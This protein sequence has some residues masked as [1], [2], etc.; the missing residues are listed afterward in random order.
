MAGFFEVLGG[1]LVWR[2]VAAPDMTA[3]QADAQMN[4]PVAGLQTVFAT[5]GARRHFMDH[6]KMRARHRITFSKYEMNVSWIHARAKSAS[7]Q[8]F[9]VLVD[10]ADGNRPFANG[11]GHALNG[12]RAHVADGKYARYA[13]L[14]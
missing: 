2:R 4:P 6:I 3:G 9:Q 12:V 14:Q 10:K 8:I 1:V 5:I 7:L 13:R 11:G